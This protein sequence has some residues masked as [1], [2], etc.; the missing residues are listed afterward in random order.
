MP[1]PVNLND[2]KTIL[3]P[4]KKPINDLKSQKSVN[5]TIKNAKVFNGTIEIRDVHII[6]NMN[7]KM[8]NQLKTKPN[9]YFNRLYKALL[10]Y[11]EEDDD[12]NIEVDTLD[13]LEL[14]D[15]I[16]TILK[17]FTQY[18]FIGMIYKDLDNIELNEDLYDHNSELAQGRCGCN[19]SIAFH[20]VFKNIYNN[21]ALWLGSKCVK[22]YYEEDD[23]KALSSVIGKV[24]Y[25]CKDCDVKYLN[26]T[27]CKC[28]YE[29]C[30]TCSDYTTG[31]CYKCDTCEVCNKLECDHV[32]CKTCGE[33]N[34]G[35]CYKCDTC[36]L[37]YRLECTCDQC[38]LCDQSFIKKYHYSVVCIDCYFKNAKQCIECEGRFF[39]FNKT[40]N[41]LYNASKCYKC[42]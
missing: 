20:F 39:P 2:K 12:R 36:K 37:C 29:Q 5:R 26:K 23:E 15:K 27:K 16:K 8:K 42:Y 40:T 31:I 17:V 18:K 1:I 10:E 22:Y 21:N 11:A 3:L 14:T 33:Y 13:D 6:T 32:K 35:I 41:K 4:D 19:H 24:I 7:E 9:A 34:T 38:P 28:Q 30:K 25:Q